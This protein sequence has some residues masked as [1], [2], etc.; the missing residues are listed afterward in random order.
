MKIRKIYLLA[1]NGMSATKKE[2]AHRNDKSR[3]TIKNWIDNNDDN[4]TKVHNLQIIR[5]GFQREGLD[6]TDDEILEEDM[7]EQEQN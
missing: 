4:L 6:F 1:L 2:L 5:Q 3:S 7:V